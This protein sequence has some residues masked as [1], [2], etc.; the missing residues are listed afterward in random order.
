M[1]L[2]LEQ[3]V[4]ERVKMLWFSGE[5]RKYI[6][7][8]C[9]IGAGSVTNIINEWKKDL[10]SSD[11]ESVREL[12]V[13]LKK[14]GLTLSQLGSMYRY[15]NFID[16]LGANEDQIESLIFNLLD[17]TK[18]IPTERTAESVNQLLN[19]QNPRIFRQLRFLNLLNRK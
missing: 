2:A 10:E 13:E 5:T 16:K 17:I 12:A 4:N 3:D 11:Y 1:P 6:A 19:Y 14:E 7:E 18:S 8:E 9:G 15:H